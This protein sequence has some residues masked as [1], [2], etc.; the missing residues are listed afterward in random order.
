MSL[1]LDIKDEQKEAVPGTSPVTADKVSLSELRLE[2]F[3]EGKTLAYGMFEDRFG[4]VRTQF[5]ADFQGSFDGTTLTL[6]EDF[7]YADG[8]TEV[9]NWTIRP[10]DDNTYVAQASGIEGDIIGT[11][12]GKTYHWQYQMGIPILGKPRMCDFDDWMYLQPDNVVINRVRVSWK[13]IRIGQVIIMLCK[14]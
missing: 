6:V 3:F 7:L 11:L 10:Q 4:K 9:R 5:K 14:P 13:G 8:S 2:Q 1:D 12:D